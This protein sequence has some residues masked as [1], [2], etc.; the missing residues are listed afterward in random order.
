M[1]GAMKMNLVFGLLIS[2]C[3]SQEGVYNAVVG[4]CIKA[5]AP[6]TTHSCVVLTREWILQEYTE[7]EH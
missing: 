3:C 1:N 5:G 4:V 2:Y 6:L 7:G